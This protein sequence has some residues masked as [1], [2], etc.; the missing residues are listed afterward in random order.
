MGRRQYIKPATKKNVKASKEGPCQQS[1]HA[2][3]FIGDSRLRLGS[4]RSESRMAWGWQRE[5]SQVGKTGFGIRNIRIMTI[6]LIKLSKIKETSFKME[7]GGSEGA[8]LTHCHSHPTRE[9]GRIYFFPAKYLIFIRTSL[10]VAFRFGLWIQPNQWETAT[11]SQWEAVTTQSSSGKG[12]S[13][14]PFIF[15]MKSSPFPLSFMKTYPW[16]TMV[17]LSWIASPLLSLI[18][19]FCW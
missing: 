2:V 19:P 12:S 15:L 14:L 4:W 17:C 6:L 1:W 7:S 10:A 16:F 13:Q 8:A 3:P 5:D 11:R 18:N 9:E